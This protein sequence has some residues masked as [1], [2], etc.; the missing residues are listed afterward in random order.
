[1]LHHDLFFTKLPCSLLPSHW[2]AESRLFDSDIQET[3]KAY[4]LHIDLPGV[5]REQ[6]DIAIEDKVLQ[7]SVN[8]KQEDPEGPK[9][10]YLQQERRHVTGKRSFR[11]GD[12]VDRETVAA[13]LANGILRIELG[14][15]ETSESRRIELS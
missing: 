2:E 10:R 3:D 4:V 6:V 1:M 11:L 15:R 13:K 9:A 8:A 5:D 7:V 14:K 12:Q